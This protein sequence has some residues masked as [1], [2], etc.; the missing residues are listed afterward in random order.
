[1]QDGEELE[2]LF[3]GGKIRSMQEKSLLLD[4]S[5]IK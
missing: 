1:M 2:P 3:F 5:P 4:S